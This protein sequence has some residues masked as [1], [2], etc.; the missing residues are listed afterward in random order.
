MSG[1]CPPHQ[2]FANLK[3]V[4]DPAPRIEIVDPNVIPQFLLHY[5]QLGS[6]FESE[7]VESTSILVDDKGMPIDLDKESCE[8]L[9]SSRSAA[10]I[11]HVWRTGSDC[12]SEALAASGEKSS[13]IRIDPKTGAATPEFLTAWGLICYLTVKDQGPVAWRYVPILI[14]RHGTSSR[15]GELRESVRIPNVL[16]GR[17]AATRSNGGR[18]TTASRRTLPN[19]W[20]F[21]PLRT[22]RSKKLSTNCRL[23]PVSYMHGIGLDLF[24]AHVSE[25]FNRCSVGAS[26]TVAAAGSRVPVMPVAVRVSM[27]CGASSMRF[28]T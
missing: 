15:R 6:S 23:N 18:K 27:S 12:A 10:L 26:G 20:T 11:K 4:V 19:D 24:S 5:G 25:R 8:K 14:A 2:A 7:S 21:G 3:V 28:F 1:W 17:S 13:R 16:L 9:A 22:T